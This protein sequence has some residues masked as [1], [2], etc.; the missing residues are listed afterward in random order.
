MSNALFYRALEIPS[1]GKNCDIMSLTE[2]V[3]TVLST[4]GATTTAENKRRRCSLVDGVCE[5]FGV[6]AA[7]KSD[8][9]KLSR[10]G[11]TCQK[12]GC[13]L[14]MVDQSDGARFKWCSA[15][16]VSLVYPWLPDRA[17]L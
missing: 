1:D 4:H 2:A 8:S 14:C 3:S 10:L 15:V 13:G 7:I 11:T 17:W 16:S 9:R 6:R 12:G 5:Q